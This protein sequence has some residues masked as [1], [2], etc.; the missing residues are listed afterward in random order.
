MVDLERR[1]EA[2]NSVKE[3]RAIMHNDPNWIAMMAEKQAAQDAFKAE[4]AQAEKPLIED[5][6]AAGFDVESA[7]FLDGENPDYVPILLDH[8]ECDYPDRVR[9]GIARALSVRSMRAELW[10]KLVALYKAEPQGTE[11]KDGLAATL[12]NLSDNSTLDETISLIDDLSNGTSRLLL[13][14][15]VSRSRQSQALEAL[16]RYVNDPYLAPQAKH[17]LK[18]KELYRRRKQKGSG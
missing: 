18:K 15:A 1:M 11:T 10:P 16:K 4:L 9:D 2:A 17:D 8:I 5:L 14:P 3:A 13:L 6:R 12:G 7:W